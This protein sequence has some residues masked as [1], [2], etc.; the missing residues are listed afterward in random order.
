MQNEKKSLVEEA[1][2]QMKNLEEAVTQNAK[3][4]LASTMK[5]EI[6]ELVKESLE[7]VEEAE[8]M[9]KVSE[10]EK[11]EISHKMKE[12][13]ELEVDDEES[14]DLES[15]DEF[16]DETLGDEED[17]MSLD[18]PGDELEVDDEEEVLLPLDL[19][20]ASD[21]EILKVFKAMGEEDGIIVSKDE[22]SIHL[23][24]TNSDVEYEIHTEG[25]DDEETM[26][27][28][29]EEDDVV[30]E[31]EISEDENEV[32]DY[33][34]ESSDEEY[35]EMSE[36]NYGMGKGE[37]S[38]THKGED[39]TTKKGMTKK[40]KAFE[41]EVDESMTIKPKGMGMNL[42]KKS[43]DLSEM[44]D[45]EME[46]GEMKEGSMTI[47]PKGVGM[48][49]KKKSFEMSE[50]EE[51]ETTEA[52]RTLGNGSKNDPKRHGLPKQKV[53]TVSESELAK[54]VESLRAK[55]EEYRK[56]LNI[57]REK[58]NE[59][60]VFNSNLAYATRLFTEQTT[61]KQEKINILRRFD[62]VESLKESKT[63]YKTLKEEYVSKETT[64]LSESVE[65]KVS[66][67][68]SRGASTNLIES[69]TY[70][71]PQFLRMKD[72]MSKLK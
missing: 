62:T 22:D 70:E 55:N 28:M 42:K 20:T 23:K 72:L 16:S 49:L 50:E 68:P 65:S 48:N 12:Q 59:V 58:L 26:D 24:D 1:L 36:G 3:G 19:R 6:S 51:A 10:M 33:E 29:Y 40:T 56:A 67:T 11:G 34:D 32:E 60:A 63:L 39:Y 52:A 21:N 45:S 13:A 35:E 25:E 30:Y 66:K 54:E 43:F 53:R 2:L 15:D 46:D 9:E 71:N 57:F 14:D 27:K 5:E 47:K 31:I 37:K 61:T 4:I 69:K 8:S 7:E 18:L 41:G 38:K 17:L 64:T 44:E